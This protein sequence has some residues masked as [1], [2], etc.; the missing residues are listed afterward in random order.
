MG[1][2]ERMSNRRVVGFLLVVGTAILPPGAI[3]A[4][5]VPAS[6][7][8]VLERLPWTPPGAGPRR[9][10]LE[11]RAELTR[12]PDDLT[13][14][15]AAARA[16]IARARAEADPR[17]LGHA[18]AALAP[19]WNAAEP[20]LTVQLLRATI[21]QSLH[22]FDGALDDLGRVL[23]RDPANMQAWLTQAMIQ[24]AR[25]DYGEARRSC[26]RILDGARRSPALRLTAIT[27]MSS[28]A[29]FGGEAPRSYETLRRALLGAGDVAP[30]RRLWALAVL[31]DIAARTGAP[32][33]ARVH[34]AEALVLARGDAG[35]PGDAGPPGDAG[36]GDAGLLSAYADF[37]LEQHEPTAVLA[38]LGSET[39]ADGLLLRIALAEQ[40]LGAPSLGR[41]VADLQARFAASRLRNDQRHLRE[42][43]RFTLALLHDARGALALAQQDWAVQREPEDARVLLAAA[44]AADDDAAAEGVLRWVAAHRLEDVQLVRLEREWR[45]RGAGS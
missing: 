12:D 16:D 8:Q 44:V 21:R 2:L 37:L 25:G 18:Q 13:T 31:A 10:L 29:S 32:E 17:Y 24:Q 20:P 11:R 19:W 26:A 27:C 43:A 14:A 39:R 22:D 4:P 42:E 41:H 28:V 5:F 15:L 30:D 23:A 38:L 33:A 40:D 7:E 35:L 45:R 34:Y 6:D 3:A 36:L 9:S 1:R